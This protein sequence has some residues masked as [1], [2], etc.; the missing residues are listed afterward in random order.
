MVRV[1][2]SLSLRDVIG[3]LEAAE[4]S[5]LAAA[6]RNEPPRRTYEPARRDP[7][8][9]YARGMRPQRVNN[10]RANRSASRA[11]YRLVHIQLSFN[12]VIY[13][14]MFDCR[15]IIQFGNLCFDV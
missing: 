5:S 10:V 7:I 2:K 3:K 1:N 14:S 15:V 9:D 12:L 6:R 4:T 11:P 8:I 13:A